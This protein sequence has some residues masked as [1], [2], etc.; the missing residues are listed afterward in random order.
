MSIYVG[1]AVK[2][3]R[4]RTDAQSSIDIQSTRA[5]V[6]FQREVR[7]SPAPLVFSHSFSPLGSA[8]FFFVPFLPT[9]LASLRDR[10]AE[11]SK[12]AAPIAGSS[13]GAYQQGSHLISQCL[14]VLSVACFRLNEQ[15]LLRFKFRFAWFSFIILACKSGH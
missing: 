2:Q 1:G 15:R 7:C 3:I 10:C 4:Q 8:F 11:L 12:Q 9:F 14:R 6:S 13:T 5:I